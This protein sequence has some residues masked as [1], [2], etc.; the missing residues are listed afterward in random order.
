[1]ESFSVAS[2]FA[3]VNNIIRSPLAHS[4]DSDIELL[5]GVITA[6][7]ETDRGSKTNTYCRKLSQLGH[8]L[9]TIVQ[10]VK[11]DNPAQPQLPTT[12]ATPIQRLSE[13]QLPYL[14]PHED[15]VIAAPSYDENSPRASGLLKRAPGGDQSIEL[16]NAVCRPNKRHQLE[17]NRAP[18]CLDEDLFLSPGFEY[19]NFV[20][21]FGE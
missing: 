9:L 21:T 6:F 8:T 20:Y 4:S 2:F 13:N 12:T 3:L 7:E 11:G 10:I 19:P 18:G 14:A 15:V 17:M 5:Q 16:A 1:M